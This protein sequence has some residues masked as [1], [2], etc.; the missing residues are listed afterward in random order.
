MRRVTV[1]ISSRY[2]LLH[3]FTLRSLS[4]NNE[5]RK[6]LTAGL[7]IPEI[8]LVLAH[9]TLGGRFTTLEQVYEELSKEVVTGGDSS[10]ESERTT[11]ETV[12]SGDGPFTAI[13]DDPLANSY[14]QN[15]YTPNPDPRMAE[16]LYE[17]TWGQN[18]L[19]GLDDMKVEGHK[20]DAKEEGEK[21]ESQH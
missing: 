21:V 13:L 3:S 10:E 5:T 6:V 15:L 12:K 9:G 7:T 1:G 18:E 14:V 8:N 17:R 11:F 4:P 2:F 20:Q 16:E 19:L